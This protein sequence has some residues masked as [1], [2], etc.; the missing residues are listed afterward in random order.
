MLSHCE[1]LKSFRGE[2]MRTSINLI[3]L[4]PSVPLKGD[5]LERV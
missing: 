3:N 2:A 5:V 4:S 1:L